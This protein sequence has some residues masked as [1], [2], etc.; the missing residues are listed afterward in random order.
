[1]WPASREAIS[2]LR[3]CS[4]RSVV[5]AASAAG[6]YQVL[7]GGAGKCSVIR[8]SVFIGCA[9]CVTKLWFHGR[10]KKVSLQSV[11]SSVGCRAPA[12]RLVAKPGRKRVGG[13]P[14]HGQRN[15]APQN[16]ALCSP[17]VFSS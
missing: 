4:S 11:H 6:L 13:A 1:R 9:G 5:R 14:L 15:E 7:I 10:E 3:L 16:G 12:G 2:A 17:E 8:G